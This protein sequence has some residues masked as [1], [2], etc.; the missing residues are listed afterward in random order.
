MINHNSKEIIDIKHDNKNIIF[1]LLGSE[2]VWQSVRS[3]FGKGYWVNEKP[4]IN[5]DGYK[6]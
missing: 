6:N 3:A 2:I 4:W 5:T 1:V